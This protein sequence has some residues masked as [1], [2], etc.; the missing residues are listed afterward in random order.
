M[1]YHVD[2]VITMYNGKTV[3][4]KNTD[5]EGRLLLAD[6][7]AY[8]QDKGATKIIDFATLTGACV[9]ALGVV[10]SGMIGN[11]QEWMNRVF[12]AAER[13][14]ERV[15]QLPAD[16]DYARQL[17]SDVADMKMLAVLKEE[18]LQRD[19]LSNSSS[20]GIRRGF[21]LI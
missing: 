12:Q 21:T 8:A 2:D 6:A 14:H 16:E 9:S 15:W 11:D 17:R 18:P 5:A 3:E 20:R 19:S 4:I 7:V 10:R 13:V 1:S